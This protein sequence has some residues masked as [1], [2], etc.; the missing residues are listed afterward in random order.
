MVGSMLRESL[1]FKGHNLVKAT[2]RTTLEVTKESR[3]TEKGDCIIGVKASKSGVDFDPSFKKMLSSDETAVKII[4]KVGG[5]RF[6]VK[7]R[8]HHALTL[9]HPTDLV[10]RRSSFVCSRT[11]AIQ[12]DAAAVDI[13]RSIVSKLRDPD[14][15][16]VMLIE[17]E[18]A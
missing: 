6:I 13:T 17:L 5:E 18:S 7:A 4:I 15:S 12:A 2:H 8:G 16:G 14:V 11:L 1:T 9:T 3:L 10:V